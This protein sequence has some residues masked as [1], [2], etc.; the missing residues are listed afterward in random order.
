MFYT[1]GTTGR[2]KSVRSTSHGET[3]TLD[4]L[5][6][7]NGSQVVMRHKF[8]AAELLYIIDEFEIINVHLVPTQFSRLVTAR[9]I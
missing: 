7:M 9:S 8:D 2:P 3:V 5:E 4:V 6:M 1:S